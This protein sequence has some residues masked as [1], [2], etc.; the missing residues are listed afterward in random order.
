MARGENVLYFSLYG[1]AIFPLLHCIICRHRPPI[2]GV[3]EEREVAENL[4]MRRIRTSVEWPY[5]TATNLFHV[6]HSKYNKHLLGRNRTPNRLI[7][8]QLRVVFFLYNCYVCLNR[9]KFSRFFGVV[10]PMI[11]QYLRV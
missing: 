8:Q 11:E 9:S 1:D 5:E 3:L 7:A 6:L 10:P 4:G 2:N